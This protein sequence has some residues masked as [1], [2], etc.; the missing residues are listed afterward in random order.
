MLYLYIVVDS[1]HY[2]QPRSTQNKP[3]TFW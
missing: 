1:L 2:R 3:P